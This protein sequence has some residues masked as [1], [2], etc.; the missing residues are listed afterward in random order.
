MRTGWGVGRPRPRPR[1]AT[2]ADVPA[3]AAL[4]AEAFPQDAWPYGYLEQAVA[5]ELHGTGIQVAECDGVVVGYAITSVVFE[6]AELQR[7]AVGPAHRRQGVAQTLLSAVLDDAGRRG[8]ERLLLEVR[9]TNTGALAFYER[10]GFIEIDRRPR[11][12]RDGTTAIVLQLPIDR[13]PAQ[14]R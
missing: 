8:A 11:Y 3:V 14:G 6:I 9:E 10:A 7:I 13:A 4:E 5:G 12:Y 1:P 2:P